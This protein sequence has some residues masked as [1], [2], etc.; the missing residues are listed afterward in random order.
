MARRTLLFNGL[1]EEACNAKLDLCMESMIRFAQAHADMAKIGIEVLPGVA[2][3]LEEL[4]KRQD[5]VTV[6]LVRRHALSGTF[7]LFHFALFHAEL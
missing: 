3:L 1:T 5:K 2:K 7:A 6:A 4:S